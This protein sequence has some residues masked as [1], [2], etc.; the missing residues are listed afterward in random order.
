MIIVENASMTRWTPVV[1]HVYVLH[2]YRSHYIE[3]F[4]SKELL[5]LLSIIIS[6]NS[7]SSIKNNDYLL[8][9]GTMYKVLFDQK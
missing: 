4:L 3:E 7:S 5:L 1:S 6:S 8:Y 9:I 2:T